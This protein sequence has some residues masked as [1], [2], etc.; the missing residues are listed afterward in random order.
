MAKQVTKAVAD[1][2]MKI[3]RAL[4]RKYDVIG[5]MNDMAGNRGMTPPKT[6]KNPGTKIAAYLAMLIEEAEFSFEVERPE[7]GCFTLEFD[8]MAEAANA[9][10]YTGK[11]LK[12]A[13][14]IRELGVIPATEW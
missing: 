13:S 11:L 8:R 5:V 6:L 3:L 14:E 9:Y 2:G 12:A 7:K 1:K 4:D 10:I